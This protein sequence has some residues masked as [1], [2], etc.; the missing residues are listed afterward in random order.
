VLAELTKKR[1]GAL[2]ALT[3]FLKPK[4]AGMSEV[5]ISAGV[6]ALEE[7]LYADY[8][9]KSL[10]LRALLGGRQSSEGGGDG[11]NSASGG[12]ADKVAGAGRQ[13]S[14]GEG[15]RDEQRDSSDSSAHVVVGEGGGESEGGGGGRVRAALERTGLLHKGGG[16]APARIAAAVW[17]VEATHTY[18]CT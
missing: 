14:K 2:K 3:R 5:E 17:G 10:R 16:W 4:V 8:L 7:A 11:E 12:E 1:D 9:R 6:Q 13:E 15:Q 18:K